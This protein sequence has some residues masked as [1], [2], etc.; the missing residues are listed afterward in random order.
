MALAINLLGSADTQASKQRHRRTQPLYHMLKDEGRHCGW[1]Q[2]PPTVVEVSESE[3]KQQD[4]RCIRLEHPFNVP[5]SIQFLQTPVESS[6]VL[7]GIK[8][9]IRF[10]L[11]AD[12]LVD[13][14]V[15][16]SKHVVDRR[17]NECHIVSRSSSDTRCVMILAL[18]ASLGCRMNA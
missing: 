1:K 4:G 3:A 15:R 5:F 9:H 11:T 13:V 18:S 16:L 7:A 2:I 8:D 6:A 12:V 10:D 14:L 17:R